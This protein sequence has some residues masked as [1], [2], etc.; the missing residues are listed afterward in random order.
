VR[1]S[2]GTSEHCIECFVLTCVRVGEPG[3]FLASG[4]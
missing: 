2:S 4:D 3:R 1:R